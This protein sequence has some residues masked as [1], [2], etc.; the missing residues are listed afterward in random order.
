MKARI[1]DKGVCA[2]YCIYNKIN[3]KRYIGVTVNVYKRIVSQRSAIVNKQHKRCNRFLMEEWFKYGEDV[4]DYSILEVLNNTNR[5][6]LNQ[7]ELFWMRLLDTINPSKGY[8]LRQDTLDGLVV[9]KLTKQLMAHKTK[10]RYAN[11]DERI[12]TGRKS[13][14]FWDENPL[15]K[16]NMR[17]KLELKKSKYVFY[18]ID[19]L[20][21]NVIEVYEN[22]SEVIKSNPSYKKHQIYSV[23]NGYKP[24][25]Y[26]F[27]W[28]K[29]L[30][31]CI[32]QP[33]LKD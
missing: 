22:I 3:N 33:Y 12:K 7:R 21:G 17:R 2:V 9:H 11:D 18:K 8:N 19:K 4:F 15:V 29:E 27:I 5:N 16:E 26:G 32:V 20:K 30:K 14:Q 1:E 25:I 6:F 13:K 28:R 31:D 10:L 23:C 24:S